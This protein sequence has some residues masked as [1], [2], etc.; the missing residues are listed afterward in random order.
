MD[1]LEPC[2]G[3]RTDPNADGG[4]PIQCDVL[5]QR[6][7]GVTHAEPGWGISVVDECGHALTFTDLGRGRLD[8]SAGQT[9]RMTPDVARDLAAALVQ[10]A[11]HADQ[12]APAAEAAEQPPGG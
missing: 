9:V 4:S 11:D 8:L 6:T 12:T 5:A 3:N 1:D 2:F 10:F 7:H